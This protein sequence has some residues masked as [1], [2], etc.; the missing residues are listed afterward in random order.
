MSD[1]PF[2]ALGGRRRRNR[3]RGAPQRSRWRLS[4]SEAMPP[5]SSVGAAKAVRGEQSGLPDRYSLA[6]GRASPPAMRRQS[7]VICRQEAWSQSQSVV[8]LTF[9]QRSTRHPVSLARPPSRACLRRSAS[10]DL[11]PNSVENA[12]T[13][14][15]KTSRVS[16]PLVKGA[17]SL[18][19]QHRHTQKRPNSPS[20]CD[21]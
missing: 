7:S 10:T 8:E 19:R 16:F 5:T 13:R 14:Q 4:M 2:V 11:L 17:F 21:R 6:A 3:E 1:L 12:V 20:S 18:T 9:V 15:H